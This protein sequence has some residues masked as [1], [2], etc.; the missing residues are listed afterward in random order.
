[1][2]PQANMLAISY[3]LTVLD[4]FMKRPECCHDVCWY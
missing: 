3:T 4:S 2:T 1:M